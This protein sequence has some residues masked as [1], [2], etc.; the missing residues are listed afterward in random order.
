MRR[1]SRS[2]GAPLAGILADATQGGR[3]RAVLFALL[4]SVT[5]VLTLVGIVC[6]NAYYASGR[7]RE[8]SIRAALGAS[9]RR[10]VRLALTQALV[11]LSAGGLLAVPLAVVAGR[12]LERFLFETPVVEPFM[13]AAVLLAIVSLSLLASY[14]MIRRMVTGNP[15]QALQ[16]G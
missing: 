6:M 5:L 4:A 1:Y 16:A 7:R 13:V 14:A 2:T 15:A 9:P 8:L 12:L 11:S 10:I 3:L